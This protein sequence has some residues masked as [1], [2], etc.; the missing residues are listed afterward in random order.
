[1]FCKW[2]KFVVLSLALTSRSV[3][4]VSIFLTGVAALQRARSLCYWGLMRSMQE[5]G[6]SERDET[7]SS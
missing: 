5:Y 6:K 2:R 4:S 3:F 1:M 7:N